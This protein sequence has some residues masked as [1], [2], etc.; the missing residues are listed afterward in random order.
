MTMFYTR[1]ST[2]AD[3]PH[4]ASIEVSQ[5]HLEHDIIP[6]VRYGFLLVCY[7]NFVRKTH[8]F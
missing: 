2:I 8:R 4:D 3:K 1:N 6:Y 7:S 5:G